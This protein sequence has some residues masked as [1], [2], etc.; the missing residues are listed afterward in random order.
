MTSMESSAPSLL[1]GSALWEQR[2]HLCPII[3]HST[4]RDHYL[5]EPC[6]AGGASHS[7]LPVTADS[8]LWQPGGLTPVS[9]HR[10]TLCDY[11]LRALTF[12]L[13]FSADE[14]KR[15]RMR[16]KFRPSLYLFITRVCRS[17]TGAAAV[18]RN[19]VQL[20][21]SPGGTASH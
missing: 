14:G 16:L 2:W 5:T 17:G 3:T 15:K 4:C 19:S 7:S 20:Y 6:R 18:M 13:N 10:R 1:A 8:R 11:R 12:Q 21:L 9:S